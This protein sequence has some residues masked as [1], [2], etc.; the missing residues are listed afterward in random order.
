[1]KF[2]VIG[3]GPY[4][5]KF[6]KYAFEAG[7]NVEFTG[8]LPYL[9][10]VSMLKCCDIAVNPININASQ[11]IINKHADYA[12]AGLPVVSTQRCK[13]YIDLLTKYYAG[14]SCT[15]EGP[16][17]IAQSMKL[18]VEDENLRVKMG[19]GSRRMAEEVFD[20]KCSYRLIADEIM[21]IR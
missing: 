10:M 8:R 12:A 19:G 18:L 9:D 14:F 3:D 13:E 2:L 4:K 7:I 6:E 11:S 16:A 17:E 15:N 1:M 5:N 21:E 20:R